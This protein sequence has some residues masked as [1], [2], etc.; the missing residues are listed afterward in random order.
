MPSPFPGMNPYLE[1]PDVW[2][3]FHTRMLGELADRLS[4][5]VRPDYLVHIESHLWIHELPED[6]FGDELSRRL[7]GR[8]DV[9]VSETDRPGQGESGR[10][11]EIG[12]LLTAPARIAL[13]HVDIERQ[14]FLE[15]RD[16]RNRALIAIVALLSPANKKPGTDRDQYVAKRSEILA[17]PAHFV[18]I[19]LLR[20]GL[21]MPDDRRSA[22]PYG[23][24]VSRAEERPVAGFWPIGLRNQLPLIPVPLRAST[25]ATLNLQEILQH[26][27]DNGTYAEEIYQQEPEPPLEPADREWATRLISGE[28]TPA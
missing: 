15:I 5:Q 17:G 28:T 18:E 13:H 21:P 25:Q 23:V 6:G 26:V 7:L 2:S 14:R 27:Y 3:T 12:S 10:A 8:A 24:M 9:F 19:D 20:C 22:S 4:L 16:R 1:Q 11:V